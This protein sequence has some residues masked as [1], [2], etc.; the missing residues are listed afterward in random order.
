MLWLLLAPIVIMPAIL[1]DIVLPTLLAAVIGL[2]IGA[3]LAWQAFSSLSK[4]EG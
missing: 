1:L 4:P 3:W 2:P